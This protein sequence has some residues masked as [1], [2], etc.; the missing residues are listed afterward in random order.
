[1]KQLIISSLVF[2]I[3]GCQAD[4]R[5]RLLDDYTRHLQ[6]LSEIESYGYRSH[7][8]SLSTQGSLLLTN[9][10]WDFAILGKGFF[11]FRQPDT[12]RVLYSRNGQLTLD[13]EWRIRNID[14]YDLDPPIQFRKDANFDS[15]EMIDRSGQWRYK[16]Y[17]SEEFIYEGIYIY[18]NTGAEYE[19]IGNY[20]AFEATKINANAEIV[21]GALETANFDILFKL[22]TLQGLSLLLLAKDQNNG[23]YEF[24]IKLFEELRER[25][26]N[27]KRKNDLH[28]YADA[29]E[30]QKEFQYFVY[31]LN[32]S[33]KTLLFLAE[34]E[35]F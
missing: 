13:T 19:R 3:F 17:S 2:L 8:E 10:P 6:D 22:N 24:Q 25:Y 31:E 21:S 32:Q 4:E 33:L 5:E 14:G 11:K 28:M 34:P 29:T 12:G 7:F 9:Q 20:F 26:R 1:M 35:G 15:L 23:L 30:S 18:E 16:T 27:I